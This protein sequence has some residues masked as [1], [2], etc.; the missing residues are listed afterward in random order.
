MTIATRPGIVEGHLGDS[1]S[2]GFADFT[3]KETFSN[4]EIASVKLLIIPVLSVVGSAAFDMAN[5]TLTTLTFN[6]ADIDAKTI[7][8][9]YTQNFT[10]SLTTSLVS[11]LSLTANLLGLPLLN[12]NTLIATVSPPV[13]ALLNSVTAPV[14]TLLTNLLGALGVRLGEADVRVTGATCGRAVLVQ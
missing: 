11:D 10:Q 7:R 14:D 12:L 9:A 2:A 6:K 1:S 5:N 3:N 8:T 13:V 4:T